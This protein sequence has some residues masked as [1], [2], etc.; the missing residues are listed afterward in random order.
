MLA[1][2][3]VIVLFTYRLYR[4]E[5]EKADIW[6]ES[7]ED[8][9]DSYFRKYGELEVLKAEVDFLDA[10]IEG[11]LKLIEEMAKKIKTQKKV[12]PKKKK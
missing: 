1:I 7:S 11:N 2:G 6:R 9:R 3:A 8:W 4:Q 10:S 12:T 5:C